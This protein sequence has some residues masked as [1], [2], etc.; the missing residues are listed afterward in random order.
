MA[1]RRGD[2]QGSGTESINWPLVGAF[3]LSVLA[4]LGMAFVYTKSQ[5]TSGDLSTRLT[6]TQKTNTQQQ[7]QIEAVNQ[8]LAA[9]NAAVV[10]LGNTAEYV[11]ISM[12]PT[13]LFSVNLATAN[14]NTVAERYRSMVY[15]NGVLSFELLNESG[16]WVPVQWYQPYATEEGGASQA[17]HFGGEVFYN[18]APNASYQGV[19]KCSYFNEY[20][21][22]GT[23]ASPLLPNAGAYDGGVGWLAYCGNSGIGGDTSGELF[24]G[25][26]AGTGLAFLT[27]CGLCPGGKS[28][29]NAAEKHIEI[30]AGSSVVPINI[31]NSIL[32]LYQTDTD[33]VFWTYRTDGNSSF[34]IQDSE[35]ASSALLGSPEGRNIRFE[36]GDG[37]V[38]DNGDLQFVGGDRTISTQ[39][40]N[41]LKVAPEG[42][43]S[44]QPYGSVRVNSNLVLGSEAVVLDDNG[45]SDSVLSTEA[46][47]RPLMH[48]ICNDPDGCEVSLD[49]T[50][51]V[52]GQVVT[53]VNTSP[54]T[55]TISSVPDVVVTAGPFVGG[56]YS[57]M[58]L[59]F[60][61]DRWVETSR[62]LK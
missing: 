7:K 8:G 47:Q 30:L 5:G 44:L 2:D 55:L 13:E 39:S 20:R 28:Y 31:T 51:A 26:Q 29:P 43:L 11:D 40:G 12:G 42:S 17:L 1:R 18:V 45:S 21:T 35:V 53:V 62:S 23:P 32:R 27:D 59:V 49:A 22:L 41:D 57:T 10:A 46:P 6:D 25:T 38:L 15:P 33:P 3:V 56:P 14:S 19:A 36:P 9:T 4:V 58:T 61:I 50:G 54:Q 52:S 60:A 24:L 48:I 34:Y 16:E 37:I